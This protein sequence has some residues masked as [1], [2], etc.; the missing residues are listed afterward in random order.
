MKKESMNL[1][2]W[3]K[4]FVALGDLLLVFSPAFII[5]FEWKALELSGNLIWNL[6]WKAY[7]ISGAFTVL[8]IVDLVYLFTNH[9]HLKKT[10]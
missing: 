6:N 9:I 7:A 8:M 4:F 5:G 1:K 10:E 2:W 3:I